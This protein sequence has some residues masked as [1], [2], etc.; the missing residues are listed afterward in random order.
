MHR[1]KFISIF[2]MLFIL[3]FG[4]AHADVKLGAAEATFAVR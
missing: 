3:T 2:P 1:L 4:C